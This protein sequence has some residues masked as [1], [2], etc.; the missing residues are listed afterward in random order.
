MGESRQEQCRFAARIQIISRADFA[1]DL[2]FDFRNRVTFEVGTGTTGTHSGSRTWPN[3]AR[4]GRIE[5]MMEDVNEAIRLPEVRA[6]SPTAAS[7][8]CLPLWP[9]ARRKRWV[10]T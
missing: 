3:S 9:S 5:M 6:V 4:S 2:A 8:S 7:K 10:S 1:F